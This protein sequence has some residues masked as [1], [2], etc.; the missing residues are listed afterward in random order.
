MTPNSVLTL[1]EKIKELVERV[2]ILASIYD[3]AQLLII[4]RVTRERGK[5]KFD[6]K[7]TIRMG[8][9][10]RAYSPPVM[11]CDCQY[12]LTSWSSASHAF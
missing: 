3:E 11:K 4:L 6:D 9:N 5:T 10:L 12:P 7:N 2:A 1:V 8:P